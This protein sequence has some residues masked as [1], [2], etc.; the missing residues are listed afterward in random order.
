MALEIQQQKRNTAYKVWIGDL[1]KSNISMNEN[2]LNYVELG[3]RK[4]VRVNIIANVIDKYRHNEKP[5]TSL[6]LDDSSGQMRVKSFDDT[7]NTSS[8]NVKQI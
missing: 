7:A 1:L 2:R 5:Y 8:F 3:N 4:I 6:T